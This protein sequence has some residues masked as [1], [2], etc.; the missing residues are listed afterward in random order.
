MILLPTESFQTRIGYCKT[1]LLFRPDTSNMLGFE[2]KLKCQD[3]DLGSLL[4]ASDNIGKYKPYGHHQMG[5]PSQENQLMPSLKG[6]L[7]NL[8]SESMNIPIFH[9]S[10]NLQNKTFNG[11]VN[12][13]DPNIDL[14]FLGKVNLSDSVP[15]FDF[16]A[17]ITNA[18]LYALNINRSDPDFRV[19]CY[20]I[21]NARGNSINSLN[22]EI[23][24]LNSLFVK[25]DKQ[26][27]I[28]DLSILSRKQFGP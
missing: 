25:K 1:D 24:L 7:N 14:E 28:Y 27:Q 12:V 13:H 4:D 11:S 3:F 6:L 19:S 10:G 20:L 22:G 21:A 9:L 2:G 5:Q 8:N 18:N 15:A 17:N 23:K 16:T 26:L